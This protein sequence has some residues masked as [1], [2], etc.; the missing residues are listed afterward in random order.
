M[1]TRILIPCRR[2][3]L[4]PRNSVTFENGHILRKSD[5]AI[6]WKIL[7]GPPKILVNPPPMGT[8]R[9]NMLSSV[10]KRKMSPPKKEIR[11]DTLKKTTSGT[12][13][14]SLGTTQI[15]LEIVIIPDS[16]QKSS[17]PLLRLR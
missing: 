5:L 8:D 7:P 1:E 6:K 14:P 13:M 2:Q 12:T 17:A 9:E 3:S 10:G 16:P 15:P 11:T 4:I